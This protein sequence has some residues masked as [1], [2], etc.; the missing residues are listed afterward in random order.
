MDSEDKKQ[1]LQCSILTKV[2]KGEEKTSRLKVVLKRHFDK[3]YSEE[4]FFE[5]AEIIDEYNQLLAEEFVDVWVLSYQRDYCLPYF[6]WHAIKGWITK[7]IQRD[8]KNE[9]CVQ[10]YAALYDVSE[11]KMQAKFKRS[12][13]F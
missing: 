12:M 1:K 6:K 10:V 5:I 11:K 9:M 2:K 7:N 4:L 3:K 13:C 8:F